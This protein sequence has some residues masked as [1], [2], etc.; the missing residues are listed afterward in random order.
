MKSL[1]A[2]RVDLYLL[3]SPNTPHITT[4]QPN[5]KQWRGS[6]PLSWALLTWQIPPRLGLPRHEL[7]VRLVSIRNKAG[8]STGIPVC[9]P[10]FLINFKCILFS[11][12]SLVTGENENNL[13]PVFIQTKL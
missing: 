8:G 10:V 6:K 3:T 1:C 5:L 2:K 12:S 9:Y 7:N 4:V 13:N 11:A